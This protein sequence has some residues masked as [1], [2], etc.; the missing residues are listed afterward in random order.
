[1]EIKITNRKAYIIEI[2]GIGIYIISISIAMLLYAGGTRDNPSAPGYTF[3]FNTFSDTGRLIAHNGE[4]NLAAFIFFSI[5]YCTIAITMIPFY[6]VFPRLFDGGT[7]ERKL[8]KIGAFLGIISSISFI[9]VVPTP[10]DILYAPHMFFAI[11]AYVSIFFTMLLYTITLYRSKK[12]SKEYAYALTVFTILFFIFLMMA[13]IS[14][15]L[16]IRA[17]LTIGQKFG[18]FSIFMGFSILTYGAWKLEEY[19]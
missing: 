1:M 7:L 2:I 13:L 14:L 17:L 9:G 4:S 18:R 12:F 3:W 5:A 6:L 10:A 19:N 11:M 15:S 8:T 16:E